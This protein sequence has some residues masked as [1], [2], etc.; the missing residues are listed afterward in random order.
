MKFRYLPTI[1]LS[2]L[3]NRF[4]SYT[5]FPPNSNLCIRERAVTLSQ[6]SVT[7]I[8]FGLQKLSFSFV[9]FDV[10]SLISHCEPRIFA[11]HESKS[12]EATIAGHPPVVGS[13]R[14][15]TYFFFHNL[16]TYCSSLL[17]LRYNIFF[18]SF[19]FSFFPAVIFAYILMTHKNLF[20]VF[21]FSTNPRKKA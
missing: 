21:R 8:R 18:V 10:S 7:V 20:H 1:C 11:L 13:V 6:N 2:S 4:H 9:L 16:A 17:G 15:S 14:I 19:F 5:A 12:E 3:L